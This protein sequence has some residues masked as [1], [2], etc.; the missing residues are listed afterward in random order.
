MQKLLKQAL[1][2]A[3]TVAATVAIGLSYAQSTGGAAAGDRGEGP[4]NTPAETLGDTPASPAT[5][6]PSSTDSRSTTPAPT[7]GTSDSSS[8]SSTPAPAA[9]ADPA[10][11]TLAPRADRN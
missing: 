3:G 6:A 1:V 8:T 7:N 11:A 10:P 2:A 9:P 5:P 4:R